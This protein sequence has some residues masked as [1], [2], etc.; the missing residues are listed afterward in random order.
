MPIDLNQF[1]FKTANFEVRYASAFL[2]WDQAGS[3]WNSVASKFPATVVREASPQTV[4]VK[5]G[6]K[7]DGTVSLDKTHL[8]VRRPSGDLRELTLLASAVF[9]E[10]VS[11]LQIATFS[12]VGLR[13]VFEKATKSKQEASDFVATAG[14]LH[15]RKGRHMNVDGRVLDPN[16][17]YRYEGD[18]L[19][20][21]VQLGSKEVTMTLDLPIEFSD[22]AEKVT[23]R[24]FVTFD[25]DYYAHGA[26]ATASFD[27]EA[28]IEEWLHLIRRDA[29][30]VFDA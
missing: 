30:N 7:S 19:G 3:L 14:R 4:T 16:L 28:L 1:T 13:L 12:R 10:L 11:R 15:H 5:I 23:V 9:P 26:V 18:S 24:N 8:S 17:A 6:E 25:I 21:L 2:L 29:G 27:A 22:V 20:F